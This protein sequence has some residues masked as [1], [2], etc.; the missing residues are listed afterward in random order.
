MSNVRWTAAG[1]DTPNHVPRESP[2]LGIALYGFELAAVRHAFS[3]ASLAILKQAHV[4]LS[5]PIADLGKAGV[6]GEMRA[7]NKGKKRPTAHP[8]D[9]ST[10]RRKVLQPR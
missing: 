6:S 3:L 2:L 5:L 9:F 1:N 7:D 10:P 8:L 4:K